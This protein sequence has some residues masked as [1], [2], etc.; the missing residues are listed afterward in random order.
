MKAI[1]RGSLNGRFGG[2]RSARSKGAALAFAIGATFTI[3]TASTADEG[4]LSFWLPGLCSAAL[5]QSPSNRAG[6]LPS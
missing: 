5:R 6:R 3:P 1:A 4:G 2:R